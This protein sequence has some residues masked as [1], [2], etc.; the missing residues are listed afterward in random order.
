MPGF[1]PIANYFCNLNDA[2]SFAFLD[3]KTFETMTGT[4]NELVITTL[5]RH[6]FLFRNYLSVNI[7]TVDT[8]V[9]NIQ[10]RSF[11]LSKNSLSIK[12]IMHS[13][14]IYFTLEDTEKDTYIE[15][16]LKRGQI[17][18]TTYE[19]YVDMESKKRT[20]VRRDFSENTIQVLTEDL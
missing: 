18:G 17:V 19:K 14:R 4:L 11:V 16:Q 8:F 10:E 2:L 13:N 3:E 12:G 7:Q 6:L 9:W 15:F 20:V 1:N 5:F